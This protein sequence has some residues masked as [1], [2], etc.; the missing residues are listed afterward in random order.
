MSLARFVKMGDFGIDFAYMSEI[1]YTEKFH[2]TT[3]GRS[4]V[5]AFI[6]Y[7][8]PYN[9]HSSYVK[10]DIDLLKIYSFLKEKE[11]D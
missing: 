2:K 7:Y 9:R 5:H 1:D 4:E 6:R 11:Y 10:T 8:D 3:W